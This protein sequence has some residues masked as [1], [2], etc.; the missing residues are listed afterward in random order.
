MGQDWPDPGEGR[1]TSGDPINR[2]G[3]SGGEG[4]RPGSES[5]PSAA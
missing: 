5:L 2:P 1:E 4:L 3:W